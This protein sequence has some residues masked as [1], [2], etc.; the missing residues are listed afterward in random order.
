MECEASSSRDP[1][2]KK[3]VRFSPALEVDQGFGKWKDQYVE[4]QTISGQ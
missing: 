3:A 1:K 4:E 2:G